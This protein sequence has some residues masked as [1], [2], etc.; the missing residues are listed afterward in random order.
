MK[1]FQYY[2]II[3]HIATKKPS[4]AF[5]NALPVEVVKAISEVALNTRVGH[6]PLTS[7]QTQALKRHER[8]VKQLSMRSVSI[9]RKRKLL[10]PRLLQDLLLP[11]LEKLKHG[12]A[13]EARSGHMD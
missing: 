8:A 10:K 9:K 7:Q 3:D 2:N 12:Q 13:N 4:Q 6:I 1:A 11:A 5:I